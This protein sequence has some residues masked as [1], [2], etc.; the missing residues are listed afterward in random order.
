MNLIEAIAKQEGYYVEGSRPQRNNNPGDLLFCPESQHFGAT[1]GDPR[2][3]VFPNTST[4]WK[5]LQRWLSVEGKFDAQGDLVAGYMGASLR[6]VLGRFAPGCENDTVGYLASVCTS[7]GL[8][9][10]T[11]ITPNLLELSSTYN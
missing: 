7:T 2:F 3:A 11:I 5:A 1:H 8:S 10:E 9:P 6:Q 4:G